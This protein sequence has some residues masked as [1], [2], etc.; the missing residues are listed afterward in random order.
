LPRRP[1]RHVERCLILLTVTADDRQQVGAVRDSPGKK[2]HHLRVSRADH[3]HQVVFAPDL[4]RL[5]AEVQSTDGQR[6]I[7]AVDRGAQNDD[8]IALVRDDRVG[9]FLL[10]VRKFRP[11][12]HNKKRKQQR[13]S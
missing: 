10:G 5:R 3:G 7:H 8:L 2:H 13:A 9:G 12:Y 4:R 11:Q 6:L 1:N